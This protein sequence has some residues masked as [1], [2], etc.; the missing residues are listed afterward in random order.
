MVKGLWGCGKTFLVKKVL[1]DWQSAEKKY[2]YVSLYGLSEARQIDDLLFT[3]M[4]PLLGSKVVRIGSR[5]IKGTLKAAIKIDVD[6]DG[7]DDGTL[8]VQFPDTSLLDQISTA[9]YVMVFD[10]L[11][12]CSAQIADIMGYI[13]KFV[14][15]GKHKVIII[16]NEQD[17]DSKDLEKESRYSK[18]KEKT[19]GRTFEVRPQASQA[20]EVFIQEASTPDAKAFLT[21]QA[22]YITEIYRQSQTKNLRILRHAANDFARLF[23]SLSPLHKENETALKHIL[24]LMLCFCFETRSGNLK[25]LELSKL[26]RS[27]YFRR[28]DVDDRQ[29]EINQIAEKYTLVNLSESLLSIER[30]IEIIDQAYINKDAVAAELDK[31]IYYK[32]EHT[33]EWRILWHAITVEEEEFNIALEAVRSKLRDRAYAEE[34]VILHV[35]GIMLNLAENN[36]LDMSV[37]QV[38]DYMKKYIDDVVSAGQAKETHSE[39]PIKVSG[40]AMGLGFQQIETPH[41][42]EILKHFNKRIKAYNESKYPEIAENLLNLMHE[43]TDAYLISTCHTNSKDN[44]YAD[45]PVF[46]GMSPELY[47]SHVRTID[48]RF[49]HKAFMAFKMRYDHGSLTRSLAPEQDF[50]NKVRDGWHKISDAAPFEANR[51]RIYIKNYVDEVG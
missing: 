3:A 39:L 2:L 17:I 38:K 31:C 27:G 4:H 47:I 37:D 34:S 44:I 28:Q 32:T 16:A 8:N 26:F 40:G 12:R 24:G 35:A 48:I 5:I 1:D 7:K 42:S 14:E 29:K 50:V 33:E 51:L 18:I 19:I 36:L 20:L 11:E 23:D 49:Q 46:K 41:F 30:W 6:G 25:S 10:D 9:G 13:N 45:V 21:A 43:D 22:K 15:H